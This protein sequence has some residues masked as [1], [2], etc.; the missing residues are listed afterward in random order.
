MHKELE[1]RYERN[2][3]ASIGELETEA[4]RKRREL[5]G[6][7]YQNSKWNFNNFGNCLPKTG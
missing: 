2:P 5:M 1:E 4:R 6:L 7:A 3:N